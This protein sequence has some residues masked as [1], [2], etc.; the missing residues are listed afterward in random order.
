MH[1][2]PIEPGQRRVAILGG[3]A[4]TVRLVKPAPDNAAW[5]CAM[6]SDG[7][8]PSIPSGTMFLIATKDL[9]ELILD[10][11]QGDG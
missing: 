5:T 7:S 3:R 2:S 1:E 9:R 6:E 8:A 4:V 10:E 11:P